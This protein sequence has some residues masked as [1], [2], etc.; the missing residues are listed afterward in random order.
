VLAANDIGDFV[1]TVIMESVNRESHRFEQ[2]VV[3][4]LEMIIDAAAIVI[5]KV[6]GHRSR[7]LEHLLEHRL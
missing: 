2:G 6:L 5:N 4:C 3:S 1:F 7:L